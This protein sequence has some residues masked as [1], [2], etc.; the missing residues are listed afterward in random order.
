MALLPST[1]KN[2]LTPRRGIAYF[3]P[4]NADGSEQAQIPMSPSSE[5]TFGQEPETTEYIS[6]E[7]G[8]NELLDRTVMAIPRTIALTCNNLSDAIKALYFVADLAPVD[9]VAGTVSAELTPYVFADRAISLGGA[10]NN[11][12]GIFGVS[13]VTVEVY[14]GA[15]AAP[16]DNAT[17]YAVGDAYVPVA[18]ND[19]WYLCTVAGTSDVSIPT[20]TTD[21]TSF[22]DGTATFIDMGLVE[23]ANV[24]GAD[25]EV[26]G[27]FARINIPAR[28]ALAAAVGRIPAALRKAGKTFRLSVS[29]TRAA[30]SFNQL[31]TKEDANLEGAF[32]F[33]EQNPKG[34]N[35]VWKCPRTTLAPTGDFATKSGNDYGA[36]QFEI[37]VLKPAVGAAMYQNGVPLA[38]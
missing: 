16:R 17:S 22:A 4:F 27:D 35:T 29:Y 18:S 34:T 23:V 1:H 28:G 8:L 38:A 6:A 31:A 26:D 25:F 32:Y 33:V 21:G 15:N 30:R 20:F 13:D 14:E 10:T 11:G 19:H 3:A 24:D 12:A 5:M 9:Q 37:A 36:A 2:N 7:S